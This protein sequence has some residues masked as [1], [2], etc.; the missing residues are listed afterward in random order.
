MTGRLTR[1]PL[2]VSRRS[3]SAYLHAYGRT[4]AVIRRSSAAVVHARVLHAEDLGVLVLE[5]RGV[6]DLA[7]EQ[8]VVA[9]LDRLPHLA[10]DVRD[11]LREHGRAGDRPVDVR[12][13]V[14]R[15]ARRDRP[16]PAS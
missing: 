3:S 9:D 8:R 7:E 13:T 4:L 2:P 6:D 12:E 16:R 1:N 11:R 15:L 10:L 14:E 5:E